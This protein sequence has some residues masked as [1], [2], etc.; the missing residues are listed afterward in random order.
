MK[1]Y[2]ALSLVLAFA[3]FSASAMAAADI[4]AGQV[5]AVICAGCHGAD[6]NSFNPAWPKL[7]SQHSGYLVKQLTAFKSGAR[8]NDLMAPMAMG[9]SEQDMENVAAYFASQKISAGNPDTSGSNVGEKLYRGGNLASGVT[10]CMACHG[11]RGSG[12]P[13]AG[14][15]SVAGQHAT[16]TQ[17]QLAAFASGA[18]SNN[19]ARMM[20]M[21]AAKLTDAEMQAVAAYIEGLK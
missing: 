17:A 6:G 11:P 14:F 10:A 3:G 13:A 8:T 20:Q 9:L 12:N 21:V 7:S 1:K 2:V 16:Y 15:P 5:T 19:N 4:A 18:R